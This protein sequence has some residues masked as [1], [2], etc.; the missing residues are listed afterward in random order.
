M[1]LDRFKYLFDLRHHVAIVTGAGQGNGMGIANALFDAGCNVIATDI[2]FPD[3]CLLHSDIE[4][5]IMD[6]TNEDNVC[7][8]F[9]NVLNKYKKIDILINNSGII[10]K[11][12]IDEI[13][14]KKFQAVMDVNLNG[15]VICTKNVVP[16]MKKNNWGRIVN[17]SSSQAFLSTEGYS[18]YSASKVSVTHLTRLWALE[19]AEYGIIVNALCP[20][21]VMTP[22]MKNS[23]ALK[24][25]KM[26]I[27]ELES[28]ESFISDI[29]L[30]CMLSI[31]DM[32]NWV[33]VLCSKLSNITTGNNFSITGGQVRL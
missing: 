6:V 25:K 13:D 5:H 28:A 1:N 20:S 11:S 29:P 16:Y 21:F 3:D 17:I 22:M 33:V 4:R 24:A 8:V 14:M 27:S 26:N 30:K 9:L 7:S 10:Y 2:L 15:T 18:A 12:A 31:E 32:S 19:L 23:I